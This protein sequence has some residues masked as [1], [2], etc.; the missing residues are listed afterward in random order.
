[1]TL[2]ALRGNNDNG[3]PK[4]RTRGRGEVGDLGG[5][6]LKF[7]SVVFYTSGLCPFKG[8]G[9]YT[10]SFV[11]KGIAD[12]KAQALGPKA[13]LCVIPINK[14]KQNACESFHI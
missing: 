10:L 9:T 8:F 4:H 11:R 7:V 1:M 2:R 12:R 3:V 14:N 5:P 6:F 13:C